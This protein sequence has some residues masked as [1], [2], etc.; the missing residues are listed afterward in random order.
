MQ[1]S[2]VT[3]ECGFVD[4]LKIC[5]KVAM[6]IWRGVG[7]L[8]RRLLGHLIQLERWS[9]TFFADVEYSLRARK[10]IDLEK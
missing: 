2:R 1:P 9:R 5:F 3:V 8:H 6:G 4:E 10:I 7:G